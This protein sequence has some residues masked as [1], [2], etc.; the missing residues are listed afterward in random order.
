MCV[1]SMCCWLQKTFLKKSTE[2]II[3][4]I[5]ISECNYFIPVIDP[6]YCFC[7]ILLATFQYLLLFFVYNGAFGI[8]H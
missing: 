1:N 2:I 6:N 5:T 7:L 3:N 8:A 4:S